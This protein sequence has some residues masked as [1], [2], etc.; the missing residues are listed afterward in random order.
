[1]NLVISSSLL[2][3]CLDI[4]ESYLMVR[5]MVVVVLASP[6]LSEH[7]LLYPVDHVR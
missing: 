3:L 4:M 2:F 7:V 1:M 5:V 6:E